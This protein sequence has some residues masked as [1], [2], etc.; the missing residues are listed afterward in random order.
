MKLTSCPATGVLLSMLVGT[1]AQSQ[2]PAPA[3]ED[4]SL[5][6]FL[7]RFEDGVSRFLNGDPAAWKQHA[8]GRDDVTVMGA[9]GAY[10]RGWREAGPRYDWA[11]A[12]FRDSGAPV[13]VSS[14]LPPNTRDQ[15]PPSCHEP[16]PGAASVRSC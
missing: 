6:A 7:A 14:L 4:P 15:G 3:T 11:A 8:S 2:A 13:L 16:S 10:E 1:A 5:S 12:R 9:W